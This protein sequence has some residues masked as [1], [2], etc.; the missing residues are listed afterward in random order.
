MELTELA[1]GQSS[2]ANDNINAN[3]DP[4]WNVECQSDYEDSDTLVTPPR[5]DEEDVGIRR[6]QPKFNYST[7]MR[8]KIKLQVGIKFANTMSLGRLLSN[9][10]LRMELISII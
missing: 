6:R 10:A 4:A 9:L 5:S 2:N 7:D 3:I 8:K 1:I